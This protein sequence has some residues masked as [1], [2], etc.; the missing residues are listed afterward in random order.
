MNESSF[1][2][3]IVDDPLNDVPRLIFADWLSERGDPR[4]DF[5]R[6]QCQLAGLDDRDPRRLDLEWIERKWL[7]QFAPSSD[8]R[9]REST[10]IVSGVHDRGMLTKLVMSAGDFVEN[11]PEILDVCPSCEIRFVDVKR[12]WDRL[13]DCGGLSRL[14]GVDF[15]NAKLGMRRLDQFLARVDLS[16]LRSLRLGGA[17]KGRE[18]IRRIARSPNLG[19]LRDL[20]LDG[21]PTDADSL[22]LLATAP[23]GTSLT[24]L[25]L[26]G[27]RI[28]SDSLESLSRGD[29]FPK[30]KSLNLSKNS[31][32][33]SEAWQR[34]FGSP[35]FNRLHD[36]SVRDCDLAPSDIS[37]LARI[38]Q[39]FALRR[40]DL[41]G[42]E[43]NHSVAKSLGKSSCVR[44]LTH[45]SLEL[46]GLDDRL[47][48]AF[49][50]HA[51]GAT[52]RSLGLALN[53]FA[54]DGVEALTQW[55]G[56]SDLSGLDVS[57]NDLHDDGVVRL[58]QSTELAN[59]NRLDLR[60]SGI[61]ETGAIQLAATT[62]L[63][64]LT[65]LHLSY[66]FHQGGYAFPKDQRAAIEATFGSHVC[67]F[68]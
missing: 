29:V 18:A 19:G 17:A 61:R 66:D 4:G 55:S 9:L 27:C 14:S 34:F 48:R 15:Y 44:G 36:L 52:I 49:L 33:D 21:A 11:Y 22:P 59:L 68:T 43:F 39:P 63:P 10:G 58:L 64:R 60:S 51:Q 57:C 56:A 25:S 45:L 46:C 6:T 38:R 37:F 1:V 20:V 42:A 30:L 13:L 40:L 26:V 24:R 16:N 35:R 3:K 41:R 65:E 53:E 54:S 67:H 28:G 2:T 50:E 47:L 32:L 31:E 7:A 23:F 62:H 8:Q 12:D 5:I